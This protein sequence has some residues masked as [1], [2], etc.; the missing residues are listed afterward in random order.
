[1]YL[2]RFLEDRLE[3]MEVNSMR[4]NT[5]WGSDSRGFSFLGGRQTI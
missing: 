3:V 1:M 5:I 2:S 4:F